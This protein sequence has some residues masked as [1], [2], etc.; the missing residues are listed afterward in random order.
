MMN[1]VLKLSFL[2]CGLVCLNATVESQTQNDQKFQSTFP[3]LPMNIRFRIVPQYFVQLMKDD[4]KYSR[5]EALINNDS[6]PPVYDVVLAEKT[7]G[8]RIIYSTS[9]ENVNTLRRV[10]KTAY[11]TNIQFAAP[12]RTDSTSTYQIKLTDITG[13][14]IAWNFVA[15]R[16]TTKVRAGFMVRANTS[17]L[18]LMGLDQRASAMPGTTLIVGNDHYSVTNER[19]PAVGQQESVDSGTYCGSGLAVAEIMPGSELW[20]VDARPDALKADE[21]WILHT[22]GGE[23]RI[24]DIENVIDDKVVINQVDRDGSF[25][26][27]M[28]VRRVRDDLLLSSLTIKRQSH[29]FRIVFSPELPFPV[30]GLDDTTKVGFI[31]SEDD[32]T[33]IAHGNLS[34]RRR[35]NDERVDWKFDAPDWARARSIETGANVLIESVRNRG[36]TVR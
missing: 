34:V 30:L 4:P 10:G 26:L 3:I 24:L 13:Q 33:D 20:S 9:E 29:S 6:T 11:Q 22:T 2:V 17:G 5:I 8:D 19:E 35:F 23:K 18:V 14:Q 21:K 28:D 25:P 32:Q 16:K 1:R 7:S 31:V 27:R 36:K 15:S 12:A